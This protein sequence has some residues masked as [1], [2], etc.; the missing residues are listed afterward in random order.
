MVAIDKRDLARAIAKGTV[1]TLL[2]VPALVFGLY[3]VFIV[4]L[5]FTSDNI[6]SPYWAIGGVLL[7][8]AAPFARAA[9]LL[10]RSGTEPRDWLILAAFAT[11]VFLVGLLLRGVFGG[12]AGIAVRVVLGLCAAG[13]I[14]KAGWTLVVARR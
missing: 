1:L 2:A 5:Q 10:V 8:F 3:G 12:P 7:L 11:F 14:V 4:S 13:I 9:W 6:D